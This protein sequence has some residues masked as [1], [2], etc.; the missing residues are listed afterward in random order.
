MVGENRKDEFRE[1]QRPSKP[2]PRSPAG[3]SYP[4]R[5]VSRT[6]Q[7]EARFGDP[8]S[9]SRDVFPGTARPDGPRLALLAIPQY[10][11]H[12]Q[13]TSRQKSASGRRGKQVQNCSRRERSTTQGGLRKRKLRRDAAEPVTSERSEFRSLR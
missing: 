10:E 6:K 9:G 5:E 1:S 4:V 13:P 7:A 11:A 2:K 8:Q 12:P 3:Y